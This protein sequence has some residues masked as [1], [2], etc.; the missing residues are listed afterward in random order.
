MLIGVFVIC[1]LT[2]PFSAFSAADVSADYTLMADAGFTLLEQILIFAGVGGS[3]LAFVLIRIARQSVKSLLKSLDEN[4][5]VSNK[6]L[7]LHAVTKGDRKAA[8]LFEKINST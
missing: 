8:N 6:K 2:Y 7:L 1:I 5:D 3:G 4:P